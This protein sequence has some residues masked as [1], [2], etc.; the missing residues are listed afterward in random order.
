M[1]NIEHLIEN[2]LVYL[3]KNP[4]ASYVDVVDHIKKDINYGE[5]YIDAR[6]ICYICLYVRFVYIRSL[7]SDINAD[8]KN[9]TGYAKSIK[10]ADLN[11]ILSR[12]LSGGTIE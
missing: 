12:H 2:T 9:V 5:N 6:D 8:I 4:K 3:E 1:S 10:L 11:A 7:W